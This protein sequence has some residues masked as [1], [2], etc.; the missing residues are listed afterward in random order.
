[1]ISDQLGEFT[2]QADSTDSGDGGKL[3]LT[4]GGSIV[5]D[6]AAESAN[7]GPNG[8]GKGGTIT[9]D[10]AQSMTLKGAFKVNGGGSGKGG[11]ITLTSQGEMDIT[12]FSATF[13][14]NGGSSNGKGGSIILLPNDGINL[15]GIAA[16]R[17]S[18][19]GK[20]TGGGG[21]VFLNNTNVTGVNREFDILKVINVD[22]GPSA[23]WNL[24]ES[25]EPHPGLGTIRNN[26]V[27]CRQWRPDSTSRSWP[28][29]LWV[30]TGDT[31]PTEKH[32]KAWELAIDSKFDGYRNQFSTAKT[33][34]FLFDSSTDFGGF[35]NQ[36]SLT[37]AAGGVS[38][39]ISSTGEYVYCCPWQ[40]GSIGDPRVPQGIQTYD[41][42]QFKE[43]T[44]H[45]LGHVHS[46]TRS[47]GLI[48]TDG[49]WQGHYGNDVTAINAPSPCNTT[50]GPFRGIID[51]E[52]GHAV[53][54]GGSLH[55]AYV[56]TPP[57]SNLAIAGIID[58]AF[59]ATEEIHAQ[60][61]ARA[62]VGNL[63]ARPMFHGVIDNGYFVNLMTYADGQI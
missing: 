23:P 27:T 61:F 45:E 54:V 13:E 40:K 19:Q 12:T 5:V 39:R 60:L 17:F 35:C 52:L 3:T 18:A 42:N 62:A 56:T 15:F 7:A 33:E 30:A 55:S 43:V 58:P 31:A 49:T 10:S 2:L 63:G 9:K 29:R 25:D 59:S 20:G 51:L 57:S 21:Y 22:A 8:D 26:G 34:F 37:A 1:M 14:A 6:G 48:S 16:L 11:S 44:A 53:C 38:W 24:S 4:S 47:G 50:N 36:V 32:L 46:M 28:K 41:N